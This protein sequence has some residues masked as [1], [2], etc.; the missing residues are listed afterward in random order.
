MSFSLFRFK[1]ILFLATG[2][3]SLKARAETDSSAFHRFWIDNAPFQMV[4]QGMF[5]AG[6]N[7]RTGVNS[8]LGIYGFR[9][10]DTWHRHYHDN[11][12][13]W[14]GSLRYRSFFPNGRIFNNGVAVYTYNLNTFTQTAHF[15]ASGG[16]DKTFGIRENLQSIA[17]E[18]GIFSGGNKDRFTLEV[19]LG[20]GVGRRSVSYLDLSNSEYDFV[21]A[22]PDLQPPRFEPKTKIIPVLSGVFRL[23]FVILK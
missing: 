12:L 5:N 23:G 20:A 18:F 8:S 21:V 1:K 3:Y 16:Y 7:I 11:Q 4:F 14:G 2:I 6:L 22:N 10:Y 19:S 17:W 15:T 13:Y 9:F